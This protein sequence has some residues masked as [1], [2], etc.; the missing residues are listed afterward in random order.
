MSTRSV[1]LQSRLPQPQRPTLRLIKRGAAPASTAAL[2]AV[3]W[4]FGIVLAS[5][6]AWITRYQLSAD[7]VSYLDMSDAVSP[8]FTWHRLINGV[9]SPFYPFL[10]GIVRRTFQVSPSNEIVAG[11]L[12]NIGFFIFSFVCFEFFLVGAIRELE[13]FATPSAKGQPSSSLPKWA[14]LLVGYAL[15]LWGAIGGISLTRLRP[16]MLMS[17]FLYLAVGM[18]LRM[19]RAPASWTRYLALG[20]ILGFGYLAKAPMLPIGGLIL[21]MTLFA[22]ADWRPALKMAAAALALML[23]I[24]SFYFVPLSRQCGFFT[25]G[26]SSV[27]NYVVHVDRAG[28]PWYLQSSG[29]AQGSFLHPPEKIFSAPPAYAFAVPSAVTHPLRFDPSYWLAGVHPQFVW[30]RQITAVTNNTVY[31]TRLFRRLIAMEAAIFVLAVFSR[32]RK[33]MVPAVMNAWPVWSVGLA[34]CAMYTLVSI[35]PRYVAAFLVLLGFAM[36][37]GLASVLQASSRIVAA[38]VLATVVILL[39][40]AMRNTCGEYVNSPRTPN[41]DSEAA[42]ALA[43]FGLKPGDGVARISPWVSDFGAERI[44][45]V[46]I[47]AEVDHG[48]AGEFWSS[49][50]ATQAE[51]LRVFASRGAKA[52]IATSP[53][54]SA[55]NQSQWTRLGSTQYWVWRPYSQ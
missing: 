3:F 55:E 5:A 32:G 14:Y 46:Q 9:W 42:N 28:P 17:G 52:V 49:S 12:L 10:L 54:L 24:G 7:S 51:L 11:H 50:S 29:D 8:G 1:P 26:Q 37:P 34:G 43:G 47:V 30:K 21:I 18:L 36:F 35:E 23:L 53:A 33:Q 41:A 20:M 25:L 13:A 45:R 27:F 48:H 2:R 6:Q 31:L 4:I 19:H 22:V 15:F 44:L 38:V 39:Y 40:P 16:D